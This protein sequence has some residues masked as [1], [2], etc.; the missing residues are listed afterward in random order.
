MVAGSLAID[1]ACNYNSLIGNDTDIAMK[2]SN[3]SIITQK[4]GGVGQNIATAAHYSG[5]KVQLCSVV[6]DDASGKAAIELL[7]QRGL[8]TESI[9]VASKGDGTA[10]YV[11]VNDSRN[12]LVLA[13]ADMRILEGGHEGFKSTWRSK[14]A[15]SKPAWLI[16]DANWDK[17]MV[18][19]WVDAGLSV[20]SKIAFEPVSVEKSTRIFYKT[21]QDHMNSL[22]KSTT[23]EKKTGRSWTMTQLADLSTPNE[24]ELMAMSKQTST[25]D[26]WTSLLFGFDEDLLLERIYSLGSGSL[27]GI[28]DAVLLAALKLL[29][30]IPCLLTK[31]GPKGVLLTEVL[32]AEDTRLER[33]EEAGYILF[34]KTPSKFNHDLSILLPE[35]EPDSS[36]SKI[37]G[38]YMRLFPAV[39]EISEKDIVS[40]NGAGDTFLGVL[41][42]LMARSKD[43]R[44]VSDFVDVAQS[45]AVLTLKSTESVS[46]RVRDMGNYIE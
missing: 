10:R 19:R 24:L 16:V 4:L 46:P 22:V 11:A 36:L 25:V 6:G 2:T 3:P 32:Q 13:M 40:V 37:G 26:A 17:E 43:K 30:N 15:T 12:D 33:E 34:R 28:G 44:P 14:V 1:L 39:E 31:L 45:A 38:V 27:H 23:D 7:Q 8:S 18:R 9:H 29:S 42:A 35:T 5:V 20:G 41:V 21:W